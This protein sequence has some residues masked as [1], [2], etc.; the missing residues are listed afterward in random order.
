MSRR[1]DAAVEENGNESGRSTYLRLHVTSEES[2]I[3]IAGTVEGDQ[4][5]IGALANSVGII[6]NP[7]TPTEFSTVEFDAVYTVNYRGNFLGCREVGARMPGHSV[8]TIVNVDSILSFVPC[9]LR[10]TGMERGRHPT[11]PRWT[12]TCRFTPSICLE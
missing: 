11:F 3:A 10:L 2:V 4:G 8:G 5:P 7:E 12:T 6:Q 1:G 9:L